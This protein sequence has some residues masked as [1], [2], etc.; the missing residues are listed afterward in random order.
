MEEWSIKGGEDLFADTNGTL[1]DV[2]ESLASNAVDMFP[3]TNFLERDIGQAIQVI[4]EVN[5]LLEN[6][7]LL[8]QMQNL[9]TSISSKG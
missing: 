6:L 9:F 4:S 7:C 1:D 8:F 2:M 5:I 3:G